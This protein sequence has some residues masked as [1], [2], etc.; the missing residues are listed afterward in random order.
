MPD[1]DGTPTPVSDPYVL[2]AL[3]ARESGAEVEAVHDPDTGR[4]TLEWTDGETVEGLERAVRAAGPE[5]ARG[6][7]YRRRLSESAVALGAVRLATSTDGSGPRP[8]MDTT[9][10]EAFW[11]DVRLP[12]PLTEREALLVYGLLYQVH[13]DHRRNEAEPEQIC[14]LVRQTGL[15]TV[16]L[17]RPEA[18]TPAE[19]LTA[20][21]ARAHGHPAWRYCLVPMDD[22]R[23]V[24]AVDEDRTATADHLRAA[25]TLTA[26]LPDTPEAVT[27]RLRA[28]LRRCG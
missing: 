1:R 23:L 16:L 28:R 18:L 5:A 15:A 2:A 4:W 3:V 12:S 8:R 6:L 10:V 11:R 26:G 25:L 27:S 24:R 13:D 22:A 9:A 20:R 14:H 19:L 7:R 21:H 17:R